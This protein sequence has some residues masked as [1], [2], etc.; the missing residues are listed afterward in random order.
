MIS[1]SS[2]AVPARLACRSAFGSFGRSGGAARRRWSSC[3]RARAARP[4]R[5]RTRP[6]R[7]R[8]PARRGRADLP[9]RLLGLSR[10]EG[11][12]RPAGLHARQRG[13][14]NA[15]GDRQVYTPQMVVNGTKSCVGSDRAA[16][17]ALHRRRRQ[18]VSLRRG[19]RAGAGRQRR[20]SRSRPEPIAVADVW[21]LPSRARR[22][23]R[24]A[25]ART[26]G[27]RSPMPMWCAA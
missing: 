8:A 9:C 15:R 3:S 16:D 25:A 10:L 22:P 12:A 7:A 11:H 20:R 2:D 21:V 17:R 24:S 6:D 14:A 19:H 18:R 1:A 27:E 5:R 26:A 23:C 4:A 13:Y